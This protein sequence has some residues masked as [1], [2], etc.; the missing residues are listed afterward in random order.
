M[1]DFPPVPPD[2]KAGGGV[3][4]ASLSGA[5]ATSDPVEGVGS[6]PQKTAVDNAKLAG[7][8]FV[9]TAKVRVFYFGL[10]ASAA[11]FIAGTLVFLCM[12]RWMFGWQT[13]L[14]L[15][16]FFTPAT[17]VISALIRSVYA[18]ESSKEEPKK[19]DISDM[20]PSSV[21]AKIITEALKPG[22]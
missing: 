22:K 18:A 1:S 3:P 2:P 13:I 14:I 21:V 5:G 6:D 11:L 10:C 15:F 17:I 7:I 16:A 8:Q 12:S 4:I 19:E 20:L 9:H